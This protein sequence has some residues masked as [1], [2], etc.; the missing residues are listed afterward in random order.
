MNLGSGNKLS[1][2]F[3]C[4]SWLKVESGVINFT[5]ISG[6]LELHEDNSPCKNV[7]LVKKKSRDNKTCSQQDSKLAD[8]FRK[9]QSK[10]YFTV[11]LPS[12]ISLPSSASP[13]PEL[14]MMQHT[15]SILK[16]QHK[17]SKVNNSGT[18][19]SYNHQRPQKSL[20]CHLLCLAVP[21]L[22]AF[23]FWGMLFGGDK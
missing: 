2:S 19:T 17:D 20:V 18:E 9:C 22:K 14:E 23:V 11:P 21:T 3:V 10:N 16:K 7:C 6:H 13:A 8:Y 12:P 4:I 1:P 15:K 5:K